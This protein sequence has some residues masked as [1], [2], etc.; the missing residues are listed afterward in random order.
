MSHPVLYHPDYDRRPRD[1]TESADLDEET[2]PSARGLYALQA[3]LRNYRRWGFT[4][5]PENILMNGIG[6][7]N[8]AIHFIRSSE[9]IM[10]QKKLLASTEAR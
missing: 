1:R 6:W 10:I 4:P 9:F 2:S 5:R 8:S 3:T 7:K